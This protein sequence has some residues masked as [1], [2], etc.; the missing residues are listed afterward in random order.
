MKKILIIIC[1]LLMS[2]C[3]H[4]R[5]ATLNGSCPEHFPIKGNTNSYLYHT[6][7][8]PF[9]YRTK[10][11]LCFADEEAAKKNGYYSA[12]RTRRTR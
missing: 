2:G 11:E 10:A 1:A 12:V 3:A 8:S 6:P 9:Y 7:E 4:M 5:F